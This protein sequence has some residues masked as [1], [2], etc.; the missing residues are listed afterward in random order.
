MTVGHTMEGIRLSSKF[1]LSHIFQ[2]KDIT[3]GKCLQNDILIFCDGF[4]TT[5]VLEC[6]LIYIV[7]S[8][9]V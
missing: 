8:L 6:V 9:T 3:I 2:A 1:Y 5:G 7:I 4:Q